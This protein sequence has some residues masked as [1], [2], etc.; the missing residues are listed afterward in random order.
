MQYST[1]KLK[2]GFKSYKDQRL[3]RAE[4]LVEELSELIKGLA[5]YDEVAMLDGLADL[6]YVTIGAGTTY[7]L[8]LVDAFWAVHHSN[9]TKDA[10]AKNHDGNKGKCE[11]YFP[12]D[13][14]VCIVSHRFSYSVYN[15]G[16]TNV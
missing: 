8:P 14:K 13:I 1:S 3:L 15:N 10:G 12:S 9:M 6:M 16:I 7:D 2:A 4:L 11:T 5:E